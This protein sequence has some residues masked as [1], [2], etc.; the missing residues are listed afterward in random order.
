[1]T[2]DEELRHLRRCLELATEALQAGDEPFGSVLVDP[3]CGVVAS[4]QQPQPTVSVAVCG[5]LSAELPT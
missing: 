2:H 1:V 3:S 4:S 5:V